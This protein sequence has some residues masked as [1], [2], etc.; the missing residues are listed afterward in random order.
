M[1]LNSY[2][3]EIKTAAITSYDILFNTKKTASPFRIIA[4]V[5]L[6][7]G[8]CTS[9]Y[10]R[11]MSVVAYLPSSLNLEMVRGGEFVSAYIPELYLI[12]K[13]VEL[14]YE[15]AAIGI[16]SGIR[17]LTAL[18]Y[19]LG[20]LEG[21]NIL[22]IGSPDLVPIHIANSLGLVTYF[23]GKDDIKARSHYIQDFPFSLIQETGG[24]G[25]NHI[26]DFSLSHSAEHKINI[27]SCLGLRGKWCICDPNLQLDPPESYQLYMRN[28]SLC[29]F[30]EDIWTHNGVEHGKFVHL[31]NLTLNRLK[32]GIFEAKPQRTYLV[33]QIHEALTDFTSDLILIKS[34]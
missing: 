23:T 10:T 2:L 13:P 11:G 5:I 17:A 31:M 12:K 15:T 32:S 3:I 21:E 33:N 30:N 29:Y 6:E 18:H 8:R 24:L 4:G 26:L 1:E 9:A 25:V 28:S 34:S 14:S 19:C 20:V 7:C 27:I 16:A 22:I